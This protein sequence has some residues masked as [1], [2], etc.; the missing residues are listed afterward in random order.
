MRTKI[1]IG[2]VA[3]CLSGIAFAEDYPRDSS[4]NVVRTGGGECWKTPYFTANPDVIAADDLVMCGDAHWETVENKTE[5]V[6]KA[7]VELNAFFDTDSATINEQQKALVLNALTAASKNSS[8]LV[9]E[10]VVGSADDR[11][12]EEYNYEL[13][14]RRAEAMRD[15]IQSAGYT[16]VQIESVGEEI[17]IL[18]GDQPEYRKATAIGEGTVVTITITEEQVLIIDA[19]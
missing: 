13:G 11:G 3:L 9:I 4:G 10:V 15:L 16:V 7:T 17:A 8:D 1:I 5:S 18:S 6:S 2:A 12:T 19:E 14:L